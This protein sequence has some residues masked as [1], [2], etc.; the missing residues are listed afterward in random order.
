LPRKIHQRKEIAAVIKEAESKNFQ[1]KKVNSG[2]GHAKYTLYCPEENAQGCKNASCFMQI[3]GT[4][5]GPEAQKRIRRWMKKCGV[6][7]KKRQAADE[8]KQAK[9]EGQ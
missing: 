1:A 8:E 3:N 6:E 9:L 2:G 4:I 7:V 5:D